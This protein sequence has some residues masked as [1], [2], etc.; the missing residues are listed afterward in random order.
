M[1]QT[2][3][4]TFVADGLSLTNA[5]QVDTNNT[6]VSESTFLSANLQVSTSN[7]I[8]K[9]GTL[10]I[11]MRLTMP[12]QLVDPNT[13]GDLLLF[14]PNWDARMIFPNGYKIGTGIQATTVSSGTAKLFRIAW[15]YGTETQRDAAWD[16]AFVNYNGQTG[17]IAP[18]VEFIYATDGNLASD[19]RASTGS[20][21]YQL[22]YEGQ[23]GR[24]L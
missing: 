16:E 19:S 7:P 15:E 21:H 9:D 18:S 5:T 24:L 1:S 14:Y 8:R 22:R 23:R 11:E 3:N 13:A 12:T 4:Y 6:L 2:T 17:T 20:R 10:K